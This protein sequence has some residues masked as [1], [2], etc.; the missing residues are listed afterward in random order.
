MEVSYEDK[1]AGWINDYAIKRRMKFK[2]AVLELEG[3][4]SRTEA[5]A[6]AEMSF[7]QDCLTTSDTQI[8]LCVDNEAKVRDKIYLIK[9]NDSATL[10]GWFDKRDVHKES[11]PLECES[12]GWIVRETDDE[13]VLAASRNEDQWGGIWIIPRSCIYLQLELKVVE[14]ENG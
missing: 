14:D 3:K 4:L 8:R 10:R 5:K 13:I 6:R 12:V 1:L 9:W 7:A 2:E 11:T